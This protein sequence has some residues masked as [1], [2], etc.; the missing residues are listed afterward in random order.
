MNL[1]DPTKVLTPTLDG[2]ALVALSD[3][4]R[5][6]TVSEVSRRAVRGSEIGIRRSL[7]R[8]VGEGIVTTTKIGNTT[9]YSLNRDHVAAHAVLD[10]SR[11]REEL[12]MRISREVS[13]W[14]IQPSG[15]YV[16]G[17]AAR[18]DG[19]ESS[20]ID[21]LVVRPPTSDEALDS[22][23]NVPRRRSKS[24]DDGGISLD[25]NAQLSSA[26]LERLGYSLDHLRDVVVRWSGNQAQIVELTTLE[27]RR[28]ATGATDFAQNVARD[29]IRI[30]ELS[31][32][33]VYRFHTDG[34]R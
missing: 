22:T 7:A 34:A 8:L 25:V 15:V 13:A 18:G 21:L 2:P 24:T 19:S 23:E 16:F 32:A 11:L 28:E 10:L 29:H 5:P 26:S 31:G 30:F 33:S 6:L 9:A 12:W 14:K 17:S 4:G 20:D 1:S 27:W 3:A